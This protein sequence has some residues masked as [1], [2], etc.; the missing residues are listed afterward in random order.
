MRL[1]RIEPHLRR[2]LRGPC[3]QEPGRGLLVA[4][5]G[6]AD[7]TALL[8][9]LASIAREFGLTLH[10]AHLHHGLR[11]PEADADLSRVRALC[12]RLG[13]P[14]IAARCDG[15]ALMKRPGYAGENGLRIMRRRFLR[16]AQRRCGA[17]AIATA[18]TADDQLETVLMRLL[19][20]TGLRGL[21]GMRA[22]HGR[23]IKPLLEATRHEIVTDL[24][25]AKISWREDRS[26]LDPQWTRNRIRHHAIPALLQALDPTADNVGKARASLALRAAAA[27][28]EAREAERALGVWLSPTPPPLIRIQG[29]VITVAADRLVSFPIAA[30]RMVLRRAWRLAAPAG[31][32]LTRRHLAAL[33][34]LVGRSR[35]S[36]RTDLPAG[37]RAERDGDVVRLIGRTGTSPRKP[38]TRLLRPPAGGRHPVAPTGAWREP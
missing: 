23:W 38:M 32:G 7:S 27:A 20:G 31:Q 30:R 11:G 17:A 13:I 26:N 34:S 1:R 2:A 24:V 15:P 16:A 19:R 6:G 18:H 25:A 14:L 3:R 22:H 8:F 10:A 36:G 12:S 4:V 9:G 21:G 37:F 35:S 28:R 29:R 5:S 33:C